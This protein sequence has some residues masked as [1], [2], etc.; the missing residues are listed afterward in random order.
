MLR[1]EGLIIGVQ[2][3]F[4]VVVGDVLHGAPIQIVHQSDIAVSLGDRL[5]IHPQV[6]DDARSLRP[7]PA[8]DGPLHDVP[9][10]VQLRNQ[11]FSKMGV[12]ESVSLLARV[13]GVANA[14]AQINFPL[15]APRMK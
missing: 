15:V 4:P 13:R 3:G 8:R 9:G 14:S 7:L 12:S 11:A 6:S 2:A 10:L 5:L 1:G